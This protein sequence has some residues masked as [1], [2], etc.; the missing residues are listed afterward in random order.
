MAQQVLHA[1]VQLASTQQGTDNPS[2][3]FFFEATGS[4]VNLDFT[5]S[6]T[7]GLIAN[8]EEA[9]IAFFNTSQNGATHTIASYL[10]AD[11]SVA[12][13]ASNVSW[14]DITAH[15][16]GSN[17][18]GPIRSTN[19]TLAG[20]GSASA[21]PPAACAVLAYRRD[22]SGDIEHG[23]TATIPSSEGAIDQGA[24]ATHSGAT[25]PR[26]RDRGRVHIGP[27]NYGAIGANGGAAGAA[28]VTD[29]GKAF[30]YLAQ[31]HNFGLGAQWNLVQ[32]SRRNASVNPVRWYFVNPYL[33][34]VRRRSDV[35]ESRVHA[36][37]AV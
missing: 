1:R 27:L 23:P 4:N 12:A 36:W 5:A 26:A 31:T 8:P 22:Y 7:T 18:G 9:L 32:W 17:A 2:F 10:S 30:D 11:L 25:R 34:I 16:D 21:L 13:N 15:L 35:T 6:G 14:Y 3:H 29:L 37:V 19:F 24:P 28:F 20:P 33:G